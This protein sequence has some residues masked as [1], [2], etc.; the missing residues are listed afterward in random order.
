MSVEQESLKQD[1]DFKSFDAQSESAWSNGSFC[2]STG[3]HS[4]IDSIGGS[5]ANS[6][7]FSPMKSSYEGAPIYEDDEEMN[8]D[9]EVSFL[10]EVVEAEMELKRIFGKSNHS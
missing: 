7:Q 1:G 8:E 4:F 3:K 6:S 2:L 9:E 10:R 5:T